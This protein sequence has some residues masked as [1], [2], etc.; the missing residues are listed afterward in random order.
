MIPPSWQE[1]G[2]PALSVQAVWLRIGLSADGRRAV[3]NVTG[4][5]ETTKPRFMA[6]VPSA[7]SLIGTHEATDDAAGLPSRMLLLFSCEGA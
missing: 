6:P 7:A 2:L 1:I 5:I 3:N 4:I